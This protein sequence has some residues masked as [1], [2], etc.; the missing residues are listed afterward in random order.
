MDSTYEDDLFEEDFL[1]HMP[2]EPARDPSGGHIGH[3]RNEELF[4]RV[5]AKMLKRLH[6]EGGMTT[7]AGKTE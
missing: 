6:K 7:N 4:A 2:D 1:F 5:K 3:N